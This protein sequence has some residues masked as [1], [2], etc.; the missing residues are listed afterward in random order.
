MKLYVRAHV[1][2]LYYSPEKFCFQI[3]NF[4]I[5]VVYLVLEFV[6]LLLVMNL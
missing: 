6:F 2:E 5:F 3:C 4:G 1:K